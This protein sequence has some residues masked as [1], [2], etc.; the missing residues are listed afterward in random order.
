MSSANNNIDKNN[1]NLILSKIPS[2]EEVLQSPSLQSLIKKFSRKLFTQI[3]RKVIAEERKNILKGNPPSIIQEII[4]QTKIC[5]QREYQSLLQPVINGTGVILHTNLGRAPFSKEI[6]SESELSLLDYCN[7][8]Y[9]LIEGKR[10][11]RG[12]GVEKLLSILST[13]EKAL[14]VN[15]NAAAVFLIL[16]TLA[17]NK[18]VII[19]RGE[20]V[21]IGG[22]FRIPEILEQSGAH[23]REVGTTNQTFI[24]DYQEAINENTALLLKVHQSNFK[25]SGFTH[26]VKVKELKELGK[27]CNLPV[28]VDLGSGV[29]L[30]TEKFGLQHEPMVQEII[31]EGADI[32]CFSTDKLL[33]GPQGGAICGSKKYL[34]KIGS[35]PLFRALRVD[36]VTLNILQTVLLYYLKDQAL[37]KIP[38]WK[39]ISCPYKKIVS[40][41]NSIVRNLKR[42][43][44]PAILKEGETAIGGGALPGQNLPTK[45]V[46]ITPSGSVEDFARQL[47]FFHP[48]LLGRKEKKY[49]ILDPR[50]FSPEYDQVV[51][52]LIKSV[53]LEWNKEGR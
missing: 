23:L 35:H 10:G 31:K 39:M 34:K 47:R 30:P 41:S 33:G 18:E 50:S 49:F 11:E 17:K 20:L 36:K 29:F 8:E 26:M 19:S 14:V 2:V 28:I 24:Q 16:H 53:F 1:S 13:A 21:Q 22:G 46:C 48:S 9:D 43:N 40:R 51:V 25:M 52:K 5:F 37:E 7:L 44:V 6:F 32:V 3:V 12:A 42:E 45:L 4:H 27:K 15:N 38:I